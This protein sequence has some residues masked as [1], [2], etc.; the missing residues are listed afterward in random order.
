VREKLA[1]GNIES[2]GDTSLILLQNAL[3]QP[4]SW[5]LS[6]GEYQLTKEEQQ[7]LQS[8]LDQCLHG[9]PLPY[10]LG[11]WEFYGRQFIVNP[12]VL[13]PRP[14]TEIL[15]EIA[16]E[17]IQ[18]FHHPR[19]V[20]VGTGSG[21]IAVSLAAECPAA[22]VVGVDLS[23]AALHVART[24]AQHLCPGRVSFVQSD[25]ITP[26]TTQF[27]L[28]CANLPYIPRQSLAKLPVSQ[29]EPQLALDGGE[30]GL[31]AIQR[32][33]S[34]TRSRLSS[35]GVILLEIEASLGSLTLSAAQVA[36]PTAR[37]RLIRDLA[38]HDRILEIRLQ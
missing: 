13:I 27:D 8:S 4:K 21:A 33:L 3:Q 1:E 31:D 7:H 15:V 12:S 30:T 5:V 16:L 9:I 17:Q 34:Q 36:F 29:W 22:S 38:G 20:D 14:E 19:I 11:H 26:F 35:A 28:I 24:N 10:I 6:H 23:M 18:R 2:P 32:L 37:H 25:L